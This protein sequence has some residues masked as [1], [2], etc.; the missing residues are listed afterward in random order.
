M[1]VS[2]EVKGKR[3]N[4]FQ[5]NISLEHSRV[6]DAA[7]IF[8]NLRVIGPLRVVN[9]YNGESLDSVLKN[10]IYTDSPI[11][12][13][14]SFKHFERG[15]FEQGV[16]ITSGMINEFHVNDVVTKSTQ[17]SLQIENLNGDVVFE[18]LDLGGTF[19]SV[20]VTDL[21]YHSIKLSGEQYTD[22]ELIFVNGAIELAVPELQANHLLIENTLNGV[23]VDNFIRIDQPL[24]LHG[25]VVFNGLET[26]ECL[27]YGNIQ[28]S[29]LL[30]GVTMDEF[31]KTRLSRTRPQDIVAADITNVQI[32]GSL[33][34]DFI[35]GIETA[36]FTDRILKS[37]S[38]RNLLFS[39]EI[40][41]NTLHVTGNV[42]LK[43]LNG[44]N[45]NQLMEDAIWLHKPNKLLGSLTFLD[46]ANVYKNFSAYGMVN[47]KFFNNFIN[48][49]V[50]KSRPV[51]LS[52]S[53]IFEKGFHVHGNVDADFLNTLP[54]TKLVRKNDDRPLMG[55]LIVEGKITARSV[56]VQERLNNVS[57]NYLKNTYAYD[58]ER[59]IHVVKGDAK[60]NSPII[61]KNLI[62]NGPF[63]EIPNI[64]YFLN[65][66]IREDADAEIVGEKHFLSSTYFD[67]GLDVKSFNG[68][69]LSRLANEI[70]IST[71][72][73]QLDIYGLVKFTE[74]VS[75][76]YVSID[77]DLATH[78]IADCSPSEWYYNGIMTDRNEKLRGKT[79]VHVDFL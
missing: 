32:T 40:Y 25:E 42:A 3:L 46:T 73:E 60:F 68:Y 63:N 52:D 2:G 53:K 27:V 34:N 44:Q 57:V 66:I 30:N 35:N 50:F 78:N 47:D 62:I 51:V 75:A 77:T 79:F 12:K 13:V 43:Q 33:K 49:V 65:S 26:G 19:D 28:S 45:F 67:R 1:Q 55:P 37:Q 24:E 41:I 18:H 15:I 10:V 74:P 23:T 29:S 5:E 4:E 39:G 64:D 61:V 48:D 21:E 76:P 14:N 17:Q 9:N 8:R 36:K 6:I 71:L 22:A 72:N 16:T 7:T 58:P 11:V 70:V 38:V 59:N 69:D 56:E 54:T 31:E 20:N